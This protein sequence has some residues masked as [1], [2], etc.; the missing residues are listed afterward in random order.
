MVALIKWHLPLQQQ[1]IHYNY[2][3]HI[4][5]VML[6]SIANSHSHTVYEHLQLQGLLCGARGLL[7]TI[8]NWLHC[9]LFF[10]C[11]WNFYYDNNLWLCSGWLLSWSLWGI[12]KQSSPLQSF[13]AAGF[14][15]VADRVGH[16]QNDGVGQQLS[17]TLNPPNTVFMISLRLIY[18]GWK[19]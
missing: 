4:A 18:L 9:R 15:V 11:D 13:N 8:W 5:P 2:K 1:F 10:Y 7:P 12:G 19:E 16:D 14:P 3:Y 6:Q 17:T